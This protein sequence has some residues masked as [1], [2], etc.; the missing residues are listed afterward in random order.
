MS[1]HKKS[2][3]N[4]AISIF[5]SGLNE[6]K[7]E[8][9][10][11][12]IVKLKIIG[13]NKFIEISKK[14]FILHP[15]GRVIVIGAGKASS[16]M[17]HCLENKIENVIDGGIV[18][19]PY[20][21]KRNCKKIEILEASHPLPDKN[22]INHTNK[23]IELVEECSK[24]DLVIFLLSGGASSLLVKPAEGIELKEKSWMIEK[25]LKSGV[26]IN[27]LNCI[28]KHL[29]GIKGGQLALKAFPARLITLYISD[30]IENKL[31]VIGSGPTYGDS[32]TFY[33]AYKILIKKKLWE[34]SPKN[35]KTRIEMGIDGNIE[36]T[37]S[38]KLVHKNKSLFFMISDLDTALSAS[39]K[40]A[41]SLGYKTTILTNRI[42]GEAK[43]VGKYLSKIAK[44][45]KNKQ[46]TP[47][48]IICGG[49]TTVTVSGNGKGGRCQEL[50][51]SFA[52]EIQGM[53]KI[54]LLA[55][56]T[57]GK[58]GPTNSSGGIVNG[59]TINSKQLIIDSEEALRN[60]NSNVFLKYRKSLFKTGP[61]GTNVTDII[62]LISR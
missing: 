56:G 37:P 36:D 15:K 19:T 60:N 33:D 51:L 12:K 23:I 22:G 49:E 40:K 39:A 43:K 8:G 20:N 50:A 1:V 38:H 28:R 48:C 42:Q 62:I 55:S 4:D 27:E 13:K 57:D 54:V 32:T 25:L 30:V 21:Y 52:R 31:D 2:I 7:P 6:C 26:S 5:H 10:F 17:A 59:R 34:I 41:K 58:D 18:I 3:K 35:V 14:D 9:R 29:S 53:S 61:T 24:N 45:K 44:K 47:S 16:H 11:S 46:S